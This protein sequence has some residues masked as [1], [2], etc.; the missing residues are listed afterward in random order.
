[1][2][3]SFQTVHGLQDIEHLAAP[4]GSNAPALIS[5]LLL[6]IFL[7]TLATIAVRRYNSFRSQAKRRLRYLQHR[8]AQQDADADAYESGT[9]RDTVYR[10][11]HILSRGLGLNGITSLTPL[12]DELSPHKERWAQFINDLSH[13]RF[14]INSSNT[15]NIKHL[16]DDAFFWLKNWP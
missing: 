6:V 14:T 9:Q 11:A 1:M 7:I 10:L 3:Q 16:F 8:L 2:E 5:S 15:A 12:P 4:P 13:S